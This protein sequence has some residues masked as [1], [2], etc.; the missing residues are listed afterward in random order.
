MSISSMEFSVKRAVMLMSFIGFLAATTWAEIIRQTFVI[1]NTPV[2]RLCKTHNIITV[3]GQLPGPTLYARNGDTVIIKTYNRAQYNATLHW[4]GVRQFRTGWADGPEY[5]TQCPIQPGGSYTYKFT[6]IDQ[7]GTLWWHAHFS[8]LRATVY[9]A[10]VIYPREGSYYPFPK[11]FAEVQILLG[12][13]WNRDPIAVVTQANLTGAGPNISNAFT[14]NGQPGALYPCSIPDTFSFSVKAGETYLLR[15]VN[16]A[17]NNELFF[18]IANHKFTVM[19]VDASYTKPYSTDVMVISPGQTTDVLLTANRPKGKYYIAA[20]AY[21]SG[22]G[23]PFDNTTTTAILEYEGHPFGSFPIL[24][25]LPFYNDTATVT[26][27]TSGL[28]SMATE[29]FPIEVPQTVDESLITTVGL[30]LRPCP[31]GQT[32]GGPNGTRFIASMNNVSFALPTISILQAYFFGIKGVFTTDFPNNPPVQ[33]DYTA[34][35]IPRGLWNPVSG[36]R[37]KVLNYNSNVQVVFQGTNIFAAENHPMHLH[38]YDFYVVGQ[39]F[40]NYNPQT[41]PLKF[42]LVDPPRR[43]TVGVPVNGWAAIRFKADNP[44]VWFMHCH[45]DVHLTW[46]LNMV[47]LVKNGPDFWATLE[48]APLDLPRCVL[49]GQDTY[50]GNV[51]LPEA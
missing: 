26:R 34:Q 28:R 48:S 21:E 49:C 4:H 11:P 7:E 15:I 32:C 6:I 10:I 27:F 16:A 24:P 19:A 25:T 13:W 33:F 17:M 39:G 41:D 36:T 1:E 8:W 23:V 12:Q 37:V 45:L 50:I 18:K 5:I 38:G 29:E 9:G 47:F 46:G 2:T 42:N 51:I 31:Q 44:G 22:Q 3:N 35:N 43:N 30:G 40:G 20:R 14:I